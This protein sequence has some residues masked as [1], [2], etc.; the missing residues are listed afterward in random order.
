MSE[1]LKWMKEN[2]AEAVGT[3]SKVIQAVVL[4]GPALSFATP[5]SIVGLSPLAEGKWNSRL[6]IGL[7]AATDFETEDILSVL[8]NNLIISADQVLED[9]KPTCSE[10]KPNEPFYRV[11]ALASWILREKAKGNNSTWAPYISILPSYVPL[12][13]FF[14][15]DL[16]DEFQDEEVASAAR[17]S[18]RSIEGM[19]NTCSKEGLGNATLGEFAGGIALAL[20]RTFHIGSAA[21]GRGRGDLALVPFVDLLDHSYAKPN[22]EYDCH[23]DGSFSLD[24]ITSISAGEPLHLVYEKAPNSHWAM[25]YG[26]IPDDNPN[27]YALLFNT[28]PEISKYYISNFCQF[29]FNEVDEKWALYVAQTAA[30]YVNA[31]LTQPSLGIRRVMDDYGEG[32]G[33]CTLPEGRVEPRLVAALA[34]IWHYDYYRKEP[35]Y[36]KLSTLSVAYGFGENNV[37]CEQLNVFPDELNYAI[38]KALGVI[39][40][41][42]QEILGNMP[43]SYDQDMNTLGL[44]YSCQSGK[45]SRGCPEEFSSLYQELQLVLMYRISKK[46][47]LHGLSTRLLE[48]CPAPSQENNFE[49][50]DFSGSFT[51]HDSVEETD[52]SSMKRDGLSHRSSNDLSKENE[53]NEI[54]Q[55]SEA[56]VFG[57]IASA[58][59]KEDAVPENDD[60]DEDLTSKMEL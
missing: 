29:F 54:V 25:M 16:L 31:L 36:E 11:V 13:L 19:Y 14:D 7:K 46:R 3:D 20:S 37:T 59:E 8:P 24:A 10:P 50:G 12:P 55:Q 52:E 40:E 22:V 58:E 30:N 18:A 60:E 34:A 41:R 4:E 47:L 23:S 26:F 39:F 28:L 44:L 9:D 43:S 27:D 51:G 2:G 53:T 49:A 15:D 5:T 21:C 56:D 17:D 38:Q 45:S 32:K 42:A 1:L 48:I 57:E 6:G 33:Y 35:D